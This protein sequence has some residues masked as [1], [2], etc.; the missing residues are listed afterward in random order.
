MATANS[1]ASNDVVLGRLANLLGEKS[2][3]LWKIHNVLAF[4]VEALP[5]DTAAGL[6]LQNTLMDIRCDIE[7]LAET[8][9]DAVDNARLSRG[10]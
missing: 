4:I 3:H 8:L 6:P 10:Y 2:A 9:Q 5:D 7:Q 1:I